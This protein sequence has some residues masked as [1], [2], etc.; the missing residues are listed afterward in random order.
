[1]GPLTGVGGRSRPVARINVVV[2]R[3]L[4]VARL[5]LSIGEA[6]IVLVRGHGVVEI[7]WPPGR[8]ELTMM[9]LD[10]PLADLYLNNNRWVSRAKLFMLGGLFD[11][12]GYCR[13]RVDGGAV[14]FFAAQVKALF[15][16]RLV[17]GERPSYCYRQLF[18]AIAASKMAPS[19]EAYAL[20]CELST[21]EERRYP[22]V[23][24]AVSNCMA[25][26]REEPV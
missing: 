3:T 5:M 15:W 24:K 16:W 21:H 10:D 13:L 6:D 20:G 22:G 17:S 18:Q 12:G 23:T 9:F 1:M 25:Y 4:A 14:S 8:A 19:P 26:W 2:A 11:R 7:V